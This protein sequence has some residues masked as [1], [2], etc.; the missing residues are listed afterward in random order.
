MIS[1]LVGESGFGPSRLPA[2]GS[3]GDSRV[4]FRLWQTPHSRRV[5]TAAIWPA[6]IR[7]SQKKSSRASPPSSAVSGIATWAVWLIVSL[8]QG[9]AFLRAVLEETREQTAL[10]SFQFR[11]VGSRQQ[12]YGLFVFHL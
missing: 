8:R 3:G 10:A 12:F 2:N 11:R 1:F 9:R 5:C 6:S 7:R 4:Q